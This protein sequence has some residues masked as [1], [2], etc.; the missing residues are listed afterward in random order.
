MAIPTQFSVA[1]SR[2]CPIANP[3]QPVDDA[4]ALTAESVSFVSGASALPVKAVGEINVPSEL[5]AQAVGSIDNASLFSALSI[6]TINNPSL[7]T[8]ETASP[9]GDAN[10]LTTKSAPIIA[11]PSPASTESQP[12]LNAP[13]VFTPRAGTQTAPNFPLNHARILY[14]NV[15][16]EASNVYATSGQ[17]PGNARIPNTWQRWTFGNGG[18]I[19][20]EMPV[21]YQIDTVCIGSHNL[22]GSD[23]T[24]GVEWSPNLTGTLWYALA[25]GKTPLNNDAMMFYFSGGTVGARRIRVL[26]SGT[27]VDRYI[28]YISAGISLQMQRPFF[29]GHTPINESDVTEYYSSRTE[30]GN[31]IGQQIRRKGFETGAEWQNIDDGWYRTYFAPFKQVAKLRPFFFAWN[32]LEYPDDV[33][34][35]RIA[36]DISAP[37]Q[38]GTTIKRSISMNMLGAD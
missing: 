28:G 16:F 33:G 15:L 11:N 13:S 19:V 6:G 5:T 36:Q 2:K 20:F 25:P 35:C 29:N 32:L 27:G 3:T 18:E 23:Y 22:S 10:A 21:Q 31:I 26:C 17:T 30:S 37:M 24:I 12:N 4:I 34:F 7:V 14:D 38:N 8:A 1:K 9:V